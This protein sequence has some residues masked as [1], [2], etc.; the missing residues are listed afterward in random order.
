[1]YVCIYVCT[2]LVYRALY[3]MGPNPCQSVFGTGQTTM[4]C[5][6]RQQRCA[7]LPLMYEH[8]KLEDSN[9]QQ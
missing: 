3:K 2:H 5:T 6:P 4:V 1:M 8:S 9:K 7:H